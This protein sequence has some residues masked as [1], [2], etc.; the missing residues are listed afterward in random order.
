[1][2]R[3]TSPAVGAST[4][5]TQAGAGV[6][7][8]PE[9]LTGI[10]TGFAAVGAFGA[11]ILIGTLAGAFDRDVYSTEE[12]VAY[13]DGLARRRRHEGHRN[14]DNKARDVVR[15]WLA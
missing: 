13:L 1:A 11:G 8:L 5:I 4:P 14:S 2:E 15:H 9:A 10:T 3:V 6:Q 12:L 7:R